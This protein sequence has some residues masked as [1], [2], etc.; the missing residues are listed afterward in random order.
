MSVKFPAIGSRVV[1]KVIETEG[2]CTI[3]MKPGDEFELS[4]HKC[5]D[6][7]GLFYSNIAGWVTTLQLGG[8]FPFGDDPD[9]QVWECPNLNNRVKVELRRIKE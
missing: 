8:T 2:T 4:T 1:A 9:V 6:F 7:C 5:G 3:G